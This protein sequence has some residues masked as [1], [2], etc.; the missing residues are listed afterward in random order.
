M[1]RAPPVDVEG[2]VARLLRGSALPDGRRLGLGDGLGI[3]ISGRSSRVVPFDGGIGASEEGRAEERP[4]GSDEAR[5]R[6]KSSH[7][8]PR[9]TMANR[10][11][12]MRF[13]GVVNK[14]RKQGAGVDSQQCTQPEEAQSQASSRIGGETC[15]EPGETE[16]MARMERIEA[17][18]GRPGRMA[19][20]SAPSGQSR[21][22]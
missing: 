8:G 6:A 9:G 17:N 20:D 16:K 18:L 14:G 19:A 15:Q 2:L 4:R 3:G 13:P 5:G 12:G 10:R 1:I 11:Y 21:A 7:G 22:R